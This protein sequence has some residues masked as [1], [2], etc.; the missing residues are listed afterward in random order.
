METSGK[1]YEAA[2][3]LLCLILTALKKPLSMHKGSSLLK[4]AVYKL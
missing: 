3:K 1:P 4:S 2:I